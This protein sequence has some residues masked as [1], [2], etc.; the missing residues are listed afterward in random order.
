MEHVA[1]LV[2]P[3]QL[4]APLSGPI[5]GDI[6]ALPLLQNEENSISQ[7]VILAAIDSDEESPPS[8]PSPP[9]DPNQSI[10]DQ[11]DTLAPIIPHLK[12]WKYPEAKARDVM[13]RLGL[14][15]LSCTTPVQPTTSFS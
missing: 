1:G 3:A 12:E 7:E 10:F 6:S 9:F 13:K 11:M 14:E 2:A 4:V 5:T 15:W 8:L